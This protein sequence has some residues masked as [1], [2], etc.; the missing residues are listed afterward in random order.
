MTQA[1]GRA[2]CHKQQFPGDPVLAAVV[3]FFRLGGIVEG[4]PFVPGRKEPR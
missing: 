4:Q 2:P 1:D 3:W